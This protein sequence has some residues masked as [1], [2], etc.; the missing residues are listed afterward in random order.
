ME[1]NGLVAYLPEPDGACQSNAMPPNLTTQ[2]CFMCSCHVVCQLPELILHLPFFL[3]TQLLPTCLHL[4]QARIH[5]CS[6]VLFPEQGSHHKVSQYHQSKVVT[7]KCLNTDFTVR[8]N[9]NKQVTLALIPM[10]HLS[11]SQASVLPGTLCIFLFSAG[12]FTPYFTAYADLSCKSC[13]L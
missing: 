6:T 10:L 13:H 3:S 11:W 4:P 2:I 8:N 9:L 1:Q 5:H 12:V 7:A